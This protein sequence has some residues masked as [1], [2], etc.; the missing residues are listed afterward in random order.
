[1]VA[2]RHCWTG[3]KTFHWDG[4]QELGLGECQV[5]TGEGQTRHVYLVSAVSS[6]RM[7]CGNKKEGS[8]GGGTHPRTLTRG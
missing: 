2:Y 3:T 4:K 6:L 7:R 8:Q 5:Y 1:M